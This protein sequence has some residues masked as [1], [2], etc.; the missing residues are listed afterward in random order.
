MVKILRRVHTG[1]EEK[2][3]IGIQSNRSCRHFHPPEN[4]S[5]RRRR[6]SARTAN[7]VQTT[8]IFGVKKGDREDGLDSP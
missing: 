2:R 8:A 6:K 4:D 7:P 5:E 1:L 3:L